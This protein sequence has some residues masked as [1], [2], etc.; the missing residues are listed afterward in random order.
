MNIN[1]YAKINLG[2]DV[3]RKREDGY[4][5]VRMIMQTIGVHDELVIDRID[6]PGISI[7]CDRE[8]LSPGEDN[9]IHKA[10]KLMMDEYAL[11]DGIEVH[12]K[13]N[14]PVAAGLAGGRTDAAA[15]LTAVN[16]LFELG[17]GRDELMK[18]GVRI[19]ADVP[20]CI[21]GGTALSE[22]IG[23]ILTR[24]SPCP[25]CPVLL[26]KPAIGV[27][28]AYV[29]NN[30]HLD[31]VTHPDIDSVISGIDGQDIRKIARSL[32]NVLE[33]VTEREY[34]VI[35]RIKEQMSSH[36]ALAALMSGSGPTVFGLFEDEND[37]RNAYEK[38]NMSGLVSEAFITE[39]FDP[40]STQVD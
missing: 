39:I 36:G 21:M 14:I 22:G 16:E 4:H 26:A 40:C 24:L 15:T 20:Y 31:T 23:E 2:L 35:S 7:T 18:L 33:S 28:T 37:I 8:D 9:L 34:P 25:K 38:L 10:A 29:Y 30:L 5:E 19:G 17:L 3:L 6:K 13:K 27:S 1:A 11:T 32:G 12:L